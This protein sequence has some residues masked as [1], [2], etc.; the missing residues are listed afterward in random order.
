MNM[1]SSEF[2]FVNTVEMFYEDATGVYGNN[3]SNFLQQYGDYPGINN[4]KNFLFFLG[5]NI[6]FYDRTNTIQSPF[7]IKS[8]PGFEIPTYVKSTMSYGDCCEMR[9]KQLLEHAERTNRELCIFYSGGIDSTCVVVSLLKVATKSQK[10]LINIMMSFESYCENKELYEKHISNN[11]NIIPSHNF[12]STIGDP[13]YICVTAEGNDQLFGSWIM[14]QMI[15]MYG[16]KEIVHENLTHDKLLKYFN[17]PS[18]TIQ[19]TENYVSMLE[20]VA[21]KAPVEIDTASKFFW[22]CNFTLKWQ[23]VYFRILSLVSPGNRMCVVPEDNYFMFF[24]TKE[25]Q[26]WSMN[27]SDDHIYDTLKTYKYICKEY[28]FDFDKNENYKLNK[29]K[30]GSLPKICTRKPMAFAIDCNMNYYDIVPDSEL[31]LNK[32]NSFIF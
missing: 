27:S 8:F 31:L 5:K 18:N 7:N 28:I 21:A 10:K 13:K 30:I 20:H 26:L 4:F 6:T 32:N 17:K 25:F 3:K 12:V 2:Y 29:I 23:C 24:S 22:W 11:L 19:Q 15:L 14:Q 16:E 9:A 1:V